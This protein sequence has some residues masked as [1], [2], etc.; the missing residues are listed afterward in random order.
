MMQENFAATKGMAGRVMGK[1]GAALDFIYQ[2]FQI[3]DFVNERYKKDVSPSM[4]N[5][6]TAYAEAVN[7]YAKKHPDEVKSKQLFPVMPKQITAGYALQMLLMHNSIMELGKLLTKDYDYTLKEKAGKGSNA[8]AYSPNFT[9]DKKTYLIGNPH[10]PV[11]RMGNFWEVSVHSEEGY[12][13]FGVTFSVGGILPVIG[14]NRNL[15]WSHT[16]NYQN[17]SDVYQLEMHP[18]KK[19][20]YKYD[21]EWLTLEEKKAK[22]KVKIGPVVIPASKK[23]YLSKYG[24]TFKK[25]SGFYSYKSNGLC[26]LK[27]AEQWYKMGLAKNMDEFMLALDIQGLAGQTITYA[28]KEGNI[29]HLSNFIH[30][31]RDEQF[32][33]TTILKGNTSANNWNFDNCSRG[34]PFTKRLS[35]K[36]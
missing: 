6:L 21:G 20:K 26:N 16:T 32:D 24:P 31:I 34:K 35:W 12:E 10:Q 18:S 4:E 13:I 7:Q 3:D 9:T 30:P 22:L 19:N 1:K 28:D 5:M 15:G 25:K 17:S 8:M 14:N 36:L 23:Y 29:Y 11:N 2:T 33:W 27:A